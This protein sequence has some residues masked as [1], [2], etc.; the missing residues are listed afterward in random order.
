M[1][2][3][4]VQ[5]GVCAMHNTGRRNAAGCFFLSGGECEPKQVRQALHVEKDVHVGS[6]R[7]GLKQKK[8]CG[9]LVYL[10][11]GSD[12]T[13]EQIKQYPTLYDDNQGTNAPGFRVKIK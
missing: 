12:K 3:D 9:A 13:T 8:K 10:T 11:E 5:A 1:W 6:G 4:G 2:I 7:C